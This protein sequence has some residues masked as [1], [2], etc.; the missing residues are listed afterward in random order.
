MDET[1]VGM[2]L[3]IALCLA[4]GLFERAYNQWRGR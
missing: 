1:A 2:I 3:I 4:A